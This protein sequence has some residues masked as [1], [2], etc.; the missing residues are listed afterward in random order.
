MSEVAN[1]QDLRGRSDEE[2][3]QFVRDK[4]DELLRL[5]FQYSTGQL[6]NVARLKQVKK[7]IARAKTIIAEKARS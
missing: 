4:G 2:L 6:E 3:S 1:G 5:K 7:E